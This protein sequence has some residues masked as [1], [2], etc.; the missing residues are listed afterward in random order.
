MHWKRWS[1]HGDV[2]TVMRVMG[3]GR[4]TTKG[5]LYHTYTG[6]KQRCY[7]VATKSYKNY[8]G[9]GVT[10]CNRWL[11]KHGYDHFLED[12]GEKPSPK[13]T[14]DRIDNDGNYEPSNCKWA[15]R[16]EQS[17][18]RRNSNAVVGVTFKPRGSVWRA[19]LQ[20]GNKMYLYKSFKNYEDAVNA[21]KSAEL[22]Y[23]REMGRT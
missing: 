3:S 9:R 15:T 6:M 13:H 1:I 17:V 18:N 23:S 19:S 7:N 16:S 8:G 11:G 22:L 12:M 10:V 5:T 20:I 14:L 4:T 2:H 21:R